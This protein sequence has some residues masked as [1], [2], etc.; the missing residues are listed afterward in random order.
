MPAG[1]KCEWLHIKALWVAVMGLLHWYLHITWRQTYDGTYNKTSSL[2]EIQICF[3]LVASKRWKPKKHPVCPY[4]LR[5][6][7]L[8]HSQS[9]CL[10]RRNCGEMG[11]VGYVVFQR[12]SDGNGNRYTWEDTSLVSQ[13]TP[14]N[15]P[16]LFHLEILTTQFAKTTEIRIDT[17]TFMQF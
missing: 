4:P 9:C 6:R 3:S 8:S 17:F 13:I 7:T 11:T 16:L 12:H 14:N 1:P 10:T 2:W 5:N 15:F